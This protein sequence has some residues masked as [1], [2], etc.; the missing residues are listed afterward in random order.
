M[1]CTNFVVTMVTISD[2]HLNTVYIVYYSTRPSK[3]TGVYS[4][5]KTGYN[6]ML[7]PMKKTLNRFRNF[8]SL[9]NNLVV[10]IQITSNLKI[11]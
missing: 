9:F 10:Q 11:I 5:Y 8:S 1:I 3:N 4:V 2:T 6:S 7:L